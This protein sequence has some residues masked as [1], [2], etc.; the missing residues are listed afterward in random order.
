MLTTSQPT[1]LN[2]TPAHSTKSPTD[3]PST[4]IQ[5]FPISNTPELDDLFANLIPRIHSISATIQKIRRQHNYD[6]EPNENNVKKNKSIAY[7][8][9]FVQLLNEHIES[10]SEINTL[11]SKTEETDNTV[12]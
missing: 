3:A 2:P 6:N 4:T 8:R 1:S 5:Q 9:A 11:G 7:S 12:D 10:L